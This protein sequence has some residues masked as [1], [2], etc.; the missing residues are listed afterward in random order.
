MPVY[1]YSCKDCGFKFEI[2]HSMS[3]EDQKCTECG[4]LNVFKVPSISNSKHHTAT[5][6]PGKI[7]DQY[8]YDVKKEIK[9]E[10]KDLKSKEL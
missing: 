8:I 9:K 3:F 4:S 6:R 10:K 5:P 7:V 1:C 2:R